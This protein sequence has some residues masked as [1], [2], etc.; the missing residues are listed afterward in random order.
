M[1]RHPP[2]N[3]LSNS[4]SG[5]SPINVHR[6]IYRGLGSESWAGA[7]SGPLPPGHAPC[8]FCSAANAALKNGGQCRCCQAGPDRAPRRGWGVGA[9]VLRWGLRAGPPPPGLVVPLGAPAEAALKRHGRFG[10]G[11]TLT[12]GGRTAPVAQRTLF[13]RRRRTAGFEF[14]SSIAQQLSQMNHK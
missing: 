5:Q 8:L 1:R 3:S 2:L 9:N 6:P 4:N 13:A 12:S 14:C 7:S 10:A 11:C